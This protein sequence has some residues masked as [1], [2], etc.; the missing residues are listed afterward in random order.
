MG[1][2]LCAAVA[3]GLLLFVPATLAL[4]RRRLQRAKARFLHGRQALPDAEFLAQA[5]VAGAEDS[6]FLAARRA[7]AWLCDIP[8]EVVYPDDS[9]R[10]LMDL[11]FDNGFLQDI[12]FALEKQLGERLPLNYP[13]DDRL[14]FVDYVHQLAVCL[15]RK[16]T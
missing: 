7:M 13:V 14:S 10:S 1:G 2:L 8:P 9:W 15:G 5:G 11:Q 12:V 4:E 16:I 6:F 3:V